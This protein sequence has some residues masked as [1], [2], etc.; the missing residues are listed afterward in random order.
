MQFTFSILYAVSY[1]HLCFQ[2]LERWVLKTRKSWFIRTR[3]AAGGLH[4]PSG[5]PAQPLIKWLTA[6]LAALPSQHSGYLQGRCGAMVWLFHYQDV[7][8]EDKPN[9]FHSLTLPTSSVVTLEC[10][11][12]GEHTARI[13]Y[14]G[15]SV[16]ISL[17]QVIFGVIVFTIGRYKLLE[18][19]ISNSYW[20]DTKNRLTDVF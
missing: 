1:F 14:K 13:T 6:M 11:G 17:W 16:F 4:E 9:T 20:I 12:L 10:W 7:W 15:G 2:P 8:G 18:L 5:F 3:Q 19:F